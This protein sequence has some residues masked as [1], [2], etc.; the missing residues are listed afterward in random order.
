MSTNT[1]TLNKIKIWFVNWRIL[2]LYIASISSKI[3]ILLNEIWQLSNV[4]PQHGGPRVGPEMRN[5]SEELIPWNTRTSP[6]LDEIF[7]TTSGP[8][9]S[10]TAGFFQ[11][12]ARLFYI[13]KFP[14]LKTVELQGALHGIQRKIIA[15]WR[16]SATQCPHEPCFTY[17]SL[18]SG[19]HVETEFSRSVRR[20]TKWVSSESNKV[21]TNIHER[22]WMGN[23]K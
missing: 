3:N 11:W 6:G 16:K 7:S 21:E 9:I 23:F 8:N 14:G 17:K 22:C 12:R 5:P 18:L 4:L 10:Y 13:I 15:L 20:A 19:A 1:F 2:P